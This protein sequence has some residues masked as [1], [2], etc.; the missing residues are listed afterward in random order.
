[1]INTH[2]AAA[3]IT[4]SCPDGYTNWNAWVGSATGPKLAEAVSPKLDL[5]SPAITAVSHA[6]MINTHAAAG[7]VFP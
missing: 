1:M 7:F 4:T 6:S 5:N 3:D 2:A